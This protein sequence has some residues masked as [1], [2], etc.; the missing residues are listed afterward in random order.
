MENKT[1][2]VNKRDVKVNG[3]STAKRNAKANRKR[4][5]AEARQAKRDKLSVEQQLKVIKKRPGKSER[6]TTRLKNINTNR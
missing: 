3:Y 4:K 2:A 6:E 1:T 5:D